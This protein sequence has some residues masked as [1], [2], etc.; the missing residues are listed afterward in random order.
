MSVIPK[1]EESRDKIGFQIPH[2]S[3]WQGCFYQKNF[4]FVVQVYE[5]V[6]Y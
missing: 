2:S 3:E 5:D 4:T 1:N 6:P